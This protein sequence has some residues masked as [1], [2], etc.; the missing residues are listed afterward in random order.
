L[1][2]RNVARELERLSEP[3]LFVGVFFL[4]AWFGYRDDRRSVRRGRGEIET[5]RVA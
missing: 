1:A 5:R 2:R 3:L 4:I